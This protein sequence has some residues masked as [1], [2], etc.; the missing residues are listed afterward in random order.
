MAVLNKFSRVGHE[1][2]KSKNRQSDAFG[3]TLEQQQTKSIPG[4]S[5]KPTTHIITVHNIRCLHP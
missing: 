5:L 2:A 4:T 1:K 3:T